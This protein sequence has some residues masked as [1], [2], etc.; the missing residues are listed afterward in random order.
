MFETET[1][2]THVCKYKKGD[3]SPCDGTMRLMRRQ[4]RLRKEKSDKKCEPTRIVTKSCGGKGERK[5]VACGYQKAR[6]VAWTS[7]KESGVHEKV[8]SLVMEKSKGFCP[9]QKIL[10]KKCSKSQEDT[11]QKEN[12]KIVNESG[13]EKR[14][15][16]SKSSDSLPTNF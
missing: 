10:S 3:W 16:S 6:T 11:N 2:V 9:K 15:G 14:K 7:C 4:D 13:R 1:K 12:G 5:A 8:L